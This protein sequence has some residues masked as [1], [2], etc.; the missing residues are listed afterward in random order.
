MTK[1]LKYF[2]VIHN[3]KCQSMMIL[4]VPK[5]TLAILL[6]KFGNIETRG[7]KV[8]IKNCNFLPPKQPTKHKIYYSR[9]NFYQQLNK[10][11]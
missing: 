2:N 9:T 10:E 8:S 7:F 11:E 3:R 1:K 4:F 6:K 5:K